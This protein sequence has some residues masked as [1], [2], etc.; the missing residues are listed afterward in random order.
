Q[1]RS[2]NGNTDG[3]H[4]Q[5]NSAGQFIQDEPTQARLQPGDQPADE[6]HRMGKPAWIAEEPVEDYGSWDDVQ[7]VMV[8]GQHL[9]LTRM[10]RM[11]RIRTLMN[12]DIQNIQDNGWPG[13]RV[14][15]STAL[16]GL[17]SVL[18]A[19][20]AYCGLNDSRIFLLNSSSC[21]KA[22]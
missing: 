22:S 14:H 5:Q 15:R 6:H 7:K 4:Q 19:I 9:Y 17:A 3:Q 16:L 2:S 1:R 10:D 11:N 21:E 12:R 18:L 13:S 8:Q 20:F